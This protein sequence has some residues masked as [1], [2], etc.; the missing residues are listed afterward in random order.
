[1]SILGLALKIACTFKSKIISFLQG[2]I[3]G[4]RFRRRL[5]ILTKRRT[6]YKGFL[7]STGNFFRKAANTVKNAVV[8]VA[9]KVKEVAVTVYNKVKEGVKAA[10]NFI[11]NTF[12]KIVQ[13][14][15]NIKQKICDFFNGPIFQE[16]KRIFIGIIGLRKNIQKIIK[17]IKGFIQAVK[18]IL[19]G[20]VGVIKILVTAICNWQRFKNAIEE[21]IGAFKTNGD[22]RWAKVGRFIGWLMLTIVD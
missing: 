15:K 22:N 1:M 7:S 16:I 19:A 11:S 21:I 2:K 13:A 12:N 10:I 14:I 5:F 18:S 17:H 20:W 3:G 9:N 4:R 8:T 6:G